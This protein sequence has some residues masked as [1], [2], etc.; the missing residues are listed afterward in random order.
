[1]GWSRT[2]EPQRPTNTFTTNIHSFLYIAKYTLHYMTSGD[3]VITCASVNP[4]IGRANLLDY[5]SS[6]GAIVAFT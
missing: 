1:M 3:S 6:K 4:Y 5:T 2:N